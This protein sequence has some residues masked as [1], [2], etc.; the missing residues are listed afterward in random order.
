MPKKQNDKQVTTI[1]QEELLQPDRQILNVSQIYKNITK[2]PKLNE[3]GKNLFKKFPLIKT[4][5]H[6]QF[7]YPESVI[8]NKYYPSFG[9][10][11]DYFIRRCL[12]EKHKLPFE[13]MRAKSVSDDMKNIFIVENMNNETMSIL[14][15]L[16][17]YSQ[18]HFLYFGETTIDLIEYD[19]N[20]LQAIKNYIN[21]AFNYDDVLLINPILGVT[22][23]FKG[24]AD[25]I[26]DN[27]IIDIKTSK[28]NKTKRD[29]NQLLLYAFGYYKR[30]QKIINHFKIYNP[31]SGLMYSLE[32][33]FI[34]FNEFETILN[35]ELG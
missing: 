4:Q 15:E 7:E 14:P 10:F 31:L 35:N 11:I 2:Y 9:V 13:D 30:H 27:V 19:V 29:F 12:A 21:D 8:K 34:D 33:N 23:L 32:I 6:E 5:V 20:H 26:I 18:N 16:F 22:N 24:D 1:V 3:F 17:H 28:Q 25:L